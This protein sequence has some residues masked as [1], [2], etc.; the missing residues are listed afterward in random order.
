MEIKRKIYND[1]LQWKERDQGRTALLIE[2]ARR[3]GKSFIVEKFSKNEYKSTLFIDFSKASN[4]VK[5]Y[6]K[7]KL[8]ILIISFRS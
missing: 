3:V 5:K 2:G 7:Q 4:E 6:L 8:K 1:L